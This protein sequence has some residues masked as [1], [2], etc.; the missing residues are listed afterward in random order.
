MDFCIK[1]G[2]QYWSTQEDMKPSTSLV[3]FLSFVSI[4]VSSAIPAQGACKAADQV[5]VDT[6]TVTAA[7]GHELQ[8]STKAC[9]ADVLS[10]SS[11]QNRTVEKR[12]TFTTCGINGAF[13]CVTNQG[14]GPL[15]SDCLALSDAITA[16]F[17]GSFTVAP[18]FVQ[19]FSLGTCLYAW[20]NLNPVGGASLSACY[21]GLTEV[22]AFNLDHS[23]IVSGDTGGFVIPGSS[24]PGLDPAVLDWTFEVLHS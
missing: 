14:I 6:H 9:S 15:E 22:L 2:D 18:Q 16:T 13:E 3:A 23:C 4:A 17:T 12:V 19:T 24:E 11:A 8:V 10:L 5:L 7:A 20:I 21:S 1:G